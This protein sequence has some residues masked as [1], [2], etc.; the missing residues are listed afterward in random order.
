MLEPVASWRAVERRFPIAQR[1]NEGNDY[2][3]QDVS[4]GNFENIETEYRDRKGQFSLNWRPCGMRG[5][6]CG[7]IRVWEETRG[8]VQCLKWK[9]AVLTALPFRQ[10]S[11]MPEQGATSAAS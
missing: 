8:R 2:S 11:M 9:N 4:T 7:G 6:D 5:T 10:H 3:A 1:M